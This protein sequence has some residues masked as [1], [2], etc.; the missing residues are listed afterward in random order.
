M[1]LNNGKRREKTVY[2]KR[3]RRGRKYTWRIAQTKTTTTTIKRSFL[4]KAFC[5]RWHFTAFPALFLFFLSFFVSFFLSLFFHV[6]L[7]FFLL[8]RNNKRIFM[9]IHIFDINLK[10]KKYKN[11]CHKNPI[12][13]LHNVIHSIGRFPLFL[14]LTRL[15][16]GRLFSHSVF[17]EFP[18]THT[19]ER[20]TC[21]CNI[22]TCIIMNLKVRKRRERQR[23]L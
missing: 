19:K 3:K 12:K 20:T 21:T 16:Q 9:H 4:D 17:V 6:F 15:P 10:R 14:L 8:S 5:F 7:S 22:H 13:Y 2:G 23:A 18:S 1:S 11:S